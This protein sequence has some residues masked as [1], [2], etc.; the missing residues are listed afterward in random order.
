MMRTRT[1]IL[2][3]VFQMS[4]SK[5]FI[6]ALSLFGFVTIVSNLSLRDYGLLNL[7]LS[8]LSPAAAFTMF[9][10]ERLVT[11][12]AVYA[13]G[14][15]KQSFARKLLLDY[16]KITAVSAGALLIF[17]WL[18]R[19]FLDRYYDA[20]LTPFFVTLAILIISQLAMNFSSIVFEAHQRFD[21]TAK[22]FSLEGLIRTLALASLFMFHF[23]LWT[24]L[25]CYTL[26]KLFSVALIATEIHNTMRI[27]KYEPPRQNLI[28]GIV[29]RH[30]KWEVIKNISYDTLNNLWPWIVNFFVNT[31]AV[32]L[33]A[34]AQKIY[35]T[36][37]TAIPLR[38]VLFPFIVGAVSKSK[39]VAQIIVAKARKIL[40][41]FFALLAA[42]LVIGA[43]LAIPAFFPEY[44]EAVFLLQIMALHLGID[45]LGLG[46]MD[47]LYAHKQQRLL[48]FVSIVAIVAQL[49]VRIISVYLFG[50]AGLVYAWLIT[51]ALG[52]YLREKVLRKIHF[53][54]FNLR[55]LFT[56]D[57][58][59]RIIL[60][61]LKKRVSRMLPLVGK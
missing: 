44:T 25:W 31:E 60:A 4:V 20:D 40:L 61:D 48:F 45:V 24:V 2:E 27:S 55:A 5:F 23:S 11:A 3:G 52:V 50:V 18:F 10:L 30:G 41:C 1:K 14:E 28:F 16:L 29:R 46:Q 47:V 9:G 38:T 39:E 58:Y 51:T 42:A 57:E 15:G 21:L 34:F 12:D 22:M 59:D 43:P 19:S 33:Y 8:L 26:S 6:K 13:R 56:Y 32:G 53:P 37:T 36:L 49:L 54:L 7:L 35:S 17:A